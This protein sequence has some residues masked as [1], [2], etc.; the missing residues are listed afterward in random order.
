MTFLYF[1]LDVCFY[2]YT[3]IK[4][5]FLLHA[6]LEKK[7][8]KFMYFISIMAIDFLLLAKGKLFLLFMILYGIN[9]ILKLSYQNI[10]EVFLRFFLFYLIYKL[11][12]YI[13]FKTFVFDYFGFAINFLVL[14]IFHKKFFT[15]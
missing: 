5:D 6:L 14:Y 11:G 9:K 12:V 2:N 3:S 15:T 7:E 1:L 10:K 4:T 8:R 13:L